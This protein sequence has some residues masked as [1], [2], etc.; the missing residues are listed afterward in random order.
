MAKLA[1]TSTT[2]AGEALAGFVASTVI[3]NDSTARGLYTVHEDIKYKG[4][5]QVVDDV[6]K[7]IDPAAAFTD[8]ATTADISEKVLTPVQME[9]HK[10]EDYSNLYKSWNSS[11]LRS[12]QPNNYNA[13]ESLADFMVERYMTKIRTAH[14]RL[15]WLGKASVQEATVTSYTGLIPKLITGIATDVSG[16]KLTDTNY[17]FSAITAA[18]GVMTVV[19]TAN[20]RSGDVISIVALSTGTT[21]ETTADIFGNATS[22]SVLGQ[23]YVI[24]VASATTLVLK[25]N[26]N[27]QQTTRGTA[28]FSTNNTGGGTIQYINVSNVATQLAAV[29]AQLDYSAYSDPEFNLMVP[30]HVAMAYQT[31]QG[32]LATNQLGA[33]A[34][35][36]TMKYNG[37]NLQVM[38]FFPANTIVAAHKKNLHM[39]TDL[40]SDKNQLKIV[41]TGDSTADEYV[42][43]RCGFS[44][45]GQYTNGG[46]I[47][48]FYPLA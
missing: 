15:F 12:G 1:L 31:K 6:V 11:M 9:F 30:L 38:P 47:S 33:L 44:S 24:T 21:T 41:Y 27:K 29:Y 14:E 18:T 8:Q 40:L 23:S 16:T 48:V 37:M 45:D 4:I 36:K 34:E 32:E 10:Q 42:R 19:S 22:T 2:Y 7:L 3:E 39:G 25:R 17:A 26:I 13:P 28:T 46:E 43:L 5:I 20:F 35:S